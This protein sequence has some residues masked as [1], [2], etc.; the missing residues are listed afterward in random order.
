MECR[1]G[2][3]RDGAWRAAALLSYRQL[4]RL[5]LT[6]A[7]SQRCH[8]FLLIYS[9]CH[10]HTQGHE[11]ELLDQLTGG[12]V[13]PTATG[14]DGAPATGGAAGAGGGAA[15]SQGG[16]ESFR[17]S[18]FSFLR[19]VTLRRD[20]EEE[21]RVSEGAEGAPPIDPAAAEATRRAFEGAV[22]AQWQRLR[23]MR[24]G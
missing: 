17:P 2:P 15:A 13:V 11:I 5:I 10:A 20:E 9:Y 24:V 14:E 1:L 7:A 4:I 23:A 22:L 12:R 16:E 6:G 8:A 18:T 21:R 19:S 3:L